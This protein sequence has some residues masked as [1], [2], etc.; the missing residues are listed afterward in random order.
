MFGILV[1]RTIAI[2]SM[3]C[4]GLQCPIW[5]TSSIRSGWL[6]GQEAMVEVVNSKTV[7]V[8]LGTGLRV[9]V[10]AEGLERAA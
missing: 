3:D 2:A 1:R 10:E 6:D 7:G 8:S 5:S 9:V 4:S